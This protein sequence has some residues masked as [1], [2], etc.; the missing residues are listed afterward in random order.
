MARLSRYL[1]GIPPAP[2]RSHK[3]RGPLLTEG[4]SPVSRGE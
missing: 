1:A 3:A 4:A 2:V